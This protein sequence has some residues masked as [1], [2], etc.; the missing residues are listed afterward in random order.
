MSWR[1]PWGARNCRHR[2]VFYVE[3]SGLWRRTCGGRPAGSEPHCKNPG[4]RLQ[5]AGFL[6]V[7]SPPQAMRLWLHL[8]HFLSPILKMDL[9]ILFLCGFYLF[10][11]FCF[12]KSFVMG[13]GVSGGR[14]CVCGQFNI[15]SDIRQVDLP[16]W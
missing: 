1:F 10:I 8:A 3:R 7:V 11:H 12:L 2:Q 13:S 4:E 6:L 15:L 14:G 5:N 9:S 16:S